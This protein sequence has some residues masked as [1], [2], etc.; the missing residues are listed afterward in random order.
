MLTA[1]VSVAMTG[2]SQR[3]G[4]PDAIEPYAY[5][6]FLDSYPLFAFA[7]V[8]GIARLVSVASGPGPGSMPRRAVFGLAGVAVLCA[9]GLYPTF[10]GLILRGGFATGGMAFLGRSPH[11]LAYGLGAGVAAAMFGAILGLFA[12]AANRPLRPSLRR[13]GSACL[14]FLALWYGG[15]VIGL[16]HDLGLGPWPHRALR[17]GEAGL[18]ALLMLVATLPH[19]ALSVR[20]ARG[21]RA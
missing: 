12:V 7:L 10:G 1:L 2:V 8:Y 20:S 11:G 3:S 6:F 13:F 16:A 18:A 9:A 19:A 15:A 14:A 17:P 4:I 5:G 21:P